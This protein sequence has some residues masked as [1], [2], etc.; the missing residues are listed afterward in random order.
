MNVW[1]IA[2]G[3]DDSENGKRAVNKADL[4][5][6]IG[7]WGEQKIGERECRNES[8]MMEW[9]FSKTRPLS[10]EIRGQENDL[11][12]EHVDKRGG[13]VSH[14]AEPLVRDFSTENVRV[15]RPSTRPADLEEN[16]HGHDGPV[17]RTRCWN[18]DSNDTHREQGHCLNGTADHEETAG[19]RSQLSFSPDLK[20]CALTVARQY[21]I[22]T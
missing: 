15:W 12:H 20:V 22:P 3:E 17:L 4:G 18:D 19:K 8:T 6:Q 16:H 11:L 13:P 14:I 7:V 1:N 21:R 5:L 10:Q 9:V 2:V